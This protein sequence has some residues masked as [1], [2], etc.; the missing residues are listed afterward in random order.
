MYV[1]HACAGTHAARVDQGVDHDVDWGG[2][3][4]CA[5]GAA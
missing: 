2:G 1:D 5:R 3:G 4:S